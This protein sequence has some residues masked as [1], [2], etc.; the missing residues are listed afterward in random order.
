MPKFDIFSHAIFY[1]ELSF[2]HDYLSELKTNIQKKIVYSDTDQ[3]YFYQTAGDLE[4]EDLFQ[5]LKNKVEEAAENFYTE[6]GYKRSKMFVTQMWGNLMK[7]HGRITE[8]YHSN[9]LISGVFYLDLNEETSGGTVFTEPMNGIHR[10]ISLPV[11]TSTKYNTENFKINVKKQ[12]LVLF[13][14]YINHY[15]EPNNS[16]D[17]RITISFNLLPYELGNFSDLNFVRF[18]D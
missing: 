15:S 5:R 4:K 11:E 3:H 18:R 1:E 9:S 13:P 10:M 2:N 12:M 6:L 14:S 16:A 7:G 8:H 17:Q